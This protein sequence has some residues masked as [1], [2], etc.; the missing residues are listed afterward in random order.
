M[1]ATAVMGEADGCDDVVGDVGRE[2]K[3]FAAD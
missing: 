3:S 1:I 2:R